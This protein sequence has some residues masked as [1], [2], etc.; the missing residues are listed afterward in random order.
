RRVNVRMQRLH[1]S[2]K[3]LGEVGQLVDARR[4]DAHVL[5]E[6]G[7][8]AAGDELDVERGEAARKLGD[9]RLVVDGDQ[10]AQ[11]SLTTSGSSRCST[12][13]IRSTSVSR[14]S[15]GT[16]SWRRAGPLSPP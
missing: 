14:G 5:E 12:P 8:A 9:P 6:L 16:T 13:W 10:R 11:R 2:A 3:E 15:T 1:P 4:P 7:R